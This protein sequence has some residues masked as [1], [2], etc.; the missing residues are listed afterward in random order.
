VV[1]HGIELHVGTLVTRAN[2]ELWF[3]S[4]EGFSRAR[5]LVRALFGLGRYLRQ[6]Q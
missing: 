5:A 6:L 4:S 2:R 3:F 1:E